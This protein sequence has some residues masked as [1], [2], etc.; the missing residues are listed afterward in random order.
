MKLKLQVKTDEA[1]VAELVK[2]LG[3]T[4]TELKE[5]KK[6][7]GK[8]ERDLKRKLVH[9]ERSSQLRSLQRQSMKGDPMV[10]NPLTQLE[11]GNA[12]LA[13]EVHE[14]EAERDQLLT[15]M[16]E[17]EKKHN[18]DEA[19]WE[20]KLQEEKANERQGRRGVDLLAQ[21]HAQMKQFLTN[22]YLSQRPVPAPQPSQPSRRSSVDLGHS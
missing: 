6:K 21:E 9:D 5:E 20:K 12:K 17:M 1:K 7:S 22:L 2:E 15:S 13:R 3:A 16:A 14:I 4:K 8:S 19:A 11:Q 10:T 18:E